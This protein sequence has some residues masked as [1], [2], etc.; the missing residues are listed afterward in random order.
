MQQDL[1]YDEGYLFQQV[2]HGDEQ[3]FN[4]IVYYFYPTLMPFITGLTK[5]KEVAEE[6]IQETFLKL[7][8]NKGK[9][10][11]ENL[12]GWLHM[13]AVNMAYTHLKRVAVEGR[14]LAH[15]RNTQPGHSLSTEEDLVLKESETLMYNAVSR[16]PAQQQLVYKLSREDGL[17]RDEIAQQLNISPN[18]VKNHLLKAMQSIKVF[19]NK[20]TKIFF[21]FF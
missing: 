3:A 7:W 15:L 18:T 1:I 13:V 4:R 20:A 16:L 10:Q 14:L 11:T 21:N 9:L 6:I 19:M 5:S 2:A 12:G 8:I 17:S